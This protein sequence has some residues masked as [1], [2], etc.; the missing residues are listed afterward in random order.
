MEIASI[1][2]NSVDTTYNKHYVGTNITPEHFTELALKKIINENNFSGF[3]SSQNARGN[4]VGIGKN[5][6]V[7]ELIKGAYT[8]YA[9]ET[10]RGYAREMATTN[11]PET[12]DQAVNYVFNELNTKESPSVI[13]ADLQNS[14]Q[15]GDT[16]LVELLISN[17][18]NLVNAYTPEERLQAQSLYAPYL[19]DK[20]NTLDNLQASVIVNQS[21]L[22]NTTHLGY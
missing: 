9:I 10:S 22:E 6:L 21:V 8:T 13:Y 17:Y 15:L 16:H 2:K 1:V 14:L 11:Y 5:A 19:Q 20:I 12:V 3:T 18:A 7:A 4:M